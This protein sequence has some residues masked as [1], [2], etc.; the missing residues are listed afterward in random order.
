M[1]DFMLRA[2]TAGLGVAMIAGP[3]G[4][5]VVWRRMAYFGDTLAHSAL[6]G[7]ALGFLLGLNLNLS[8]VLVAVTIALLLISLQ[9]RRQLTTD[10]LLG[11]LAHSALSLGLVA[12][13]FQTSVRVD[14]MGYLFGDILAVSAGDLLWVW[15]GGAL[16]MTTLVLIWRPLLSLTVH[17]ELARVE[18]VPITRIR[19]IFMLLIALVIAVSMKIVG[20]LLI[21]SMLIIPAAAARR[22]SRTPEQMALAAAGVAAVA[23][24]LGL[25]ASWQWD[26]PAGPS[27]VVAAA[28]LFATS[29]LI[30]SI[31]S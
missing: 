3:L 19:L 5:F 10:T 27:V 25:G 11:I 2:L 30:P 14:L 23:V 16:A 8:V 1:D 18:G 4:V 31:K 22:I 21:T 20:V 13:S 29:Q 17:P 12:I 28:L 15:G 26:T 24:L 9:G 6:L 7:V